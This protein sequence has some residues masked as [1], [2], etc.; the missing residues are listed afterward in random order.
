MSN[1]NKKTK[2]K[3]NKNPVNGLNMPGSS[4]GTK[5]GNAPIALSSNK[6][7]RRQVTARKAE[8]GS[9]LLFKLDNVIKQ[10]SNEVFIQRIRP[11]IMQRC[12]K[13]A[14]TFLRYRFK[15]LRF[16]IETKMPTT[17]PGGY[18]VGYSIDPTLFVPDDQL[19][20]TIPTLPGYQSL[21]WWENTVFTPRLSS[22]ILYVN[23]GTDDRLVSDG[24]FFMV[25]DGSIT[26][27]TEGS[28]SI[29]VDWEVEFYDPIINNAPI[30]NPLL[31]N[32]AAYDVIALH[33]TNTTTLGYL[34]GCDITKESSDDRIQSIDDVF[35]GLRNYADGQ[36]FTPTRVVS[37]LGVE[38][39]VTSTEA[40]PEY[41]TRCQFYSLSSATIS[42]KTIRVLNFHN[43]SVAGTTSVGNL[44]TDPPNMWCVTG[45]SQ[46]EPFNDKY[47]FQELQGAIEPTSTHMNMKYRKYK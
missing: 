33:D 24:K 6:R 39:G 37:L 4:T 26:E 32:T 29:Y 18:I 40:V 3:S 25:T 21:K 5:Y 38:E 28:L 35:P 43:D 10:A 19:N 47:Q 31:N 12:G 16:R 14:S 44:S 17:V 45:W 30:S 1:S 20:I 7:K 11:T 27:E 15:S 34:F 22:K 41:F 42:G 13:L 36:H 23:N 8:R 2:S 9:D 46:G